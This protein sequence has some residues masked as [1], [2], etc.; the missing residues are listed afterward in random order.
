MKLAITGKGGVGKT[1][2]SAGLATL[3]ARARRPVVAI[4]ADPDTNLALALGV[5]PDDAERIVPLSEMRDLIRE[6]MG[7][8]GGEGGGF[9][10]LNPR[11]DDIADRYGTR[12]DGIRLLVV[13]AVRRGGAGCACPENVLLQ[14]L[15]EHLLV[16]SNEAVIADM[17][18]GIEHLGR[19]TARGV[20]MLVI[21]AEPS[22][23]A[24]HTAQ[25]IRH[26]AGEVGIERLGLVV[27]KARDETQAD[28]VVSAVTDIPLLGILPWREEVSTAALEGVPVAE[29]ALL[30]DIA[31]IK[32]AIERALG[33]N[34]H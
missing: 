4:D 13:G 15:L 33:S 25:T 17:E 32:T 29:T 31:L 21:V 34:T 7:A 24:I 3:F 28:R 19:G 26:L 11:V 14:T 10:A 1:T 20:D 30:E 2:L 22:R 27:N 23:A 16:D 18:A 5:P 8:A 12:I 6:R 9:V